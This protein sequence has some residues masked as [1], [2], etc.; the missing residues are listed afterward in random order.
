MFGSFPPVRMMTALVGWLICC[1][2]GVALPTDRAVADEPYGRFQFSDSDREHWSFVPPRRGALPAVKNT[3]WVKNPIDAFV[4]ARLEAEGLAPNPSADKLTLLRRVY[5]DL[6]GLAPTPA[7]QDAFL[8]DQ[9]PDA[10]ARVVDD[11]LARPAYGERWGRHWLDVVRYAESNGYERDGAK[12]SAWRYRDYVINAF[13]NDKPYDRFLTEQLAGDELADANAETCIATTFLR[14]GPWDDEPA[15]ALIDRYDQLDDVLGTASATFLAQTL[16]CARCHDHKF[17]SFTQRDYT[18]MLAV[19]EPLKRPQDGRTDLDRMVGTETELAAYQAANKTVDERVATLRADRERTEWE[20]C[21]RLAGAGLLRSPEVHAI[22]AT[23]REQPQTWR[24]CEEAPAGDWQLAEFDATSWKAGPGGFG[25]EG[26]PGTA[27]RTRW[28]S[29]ELWLR[30]DFELSAD[31]L[32]PEQLSRLQL[33]VHHDDACEI[34]L[35]GVLAA[36]LDGFTVEYKNVPIAVDAVTAL[37]PGRNVLAVHCSQTTGGQY[38]DVGLVAVEATPVAT[39]GGA[40]AEPAMLPPEAVEALLA[41]PE[42]RSSKQ[43]ELTKKLRP[44]L[45]KLL[46]SSGSDAERQ[47]SDELERQLEDADKARPAPLASAYV[48]F[49]ESPQATLSK[50]W[51]RGNPRESL[52]EVSAGFPAILVEQAPPPPAPTTKSTG[53]RLQLAQWLVAPGHPLTARVMANRIWQHHFGDGLVGTE[54][55]FGV[56]GEMPT[57]PELLDWLANEFVASGWHIKALHRLMVL[58][59][60]YQ[61]SSAPQPEAAAKDP[62]EDLLWRFPPRRLEAEAIR[63]CVLATSGQL[64]RERG[65]PS[66]YPTISADILA[67]QSRPGNGWGKSEPDQAARRSVY[68]FVKRTLLVPELE[69]LDFPDTNGT[70]EQRVVSTVAPQALT[71]LNGAFI[72]EQAQQFAVRLAREAGDNTQARVEL[73]YRLSLARPATTGERETVL[74]F[75]ARHEKQIAADAAAASQNIDPRQQALEAFCLVL[76]NSNE[77]VYVR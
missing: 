49:E 71:W 72:R 7:E 47:T 15:D 50:I 77:F 2:L 20:L 40:D 42:S 24:Y 57:H 32:P 16:R 10:L 14:L 18:R 17:E 70:C 12:P 26:T 27:V 3:D 69:V 66:V 9:A 51:K 13:N 29:A 39:G 8:A 53:R 25:T 41:P 45:K 58:S 38:I 46:A 6:I 76:L 33:A 19:F 36:K 30:R 67:S 5:L 64:N 48:W 4:L 28:A 65:G 59:N 31:A 1:A 21:K 11:L 54:N 75:L 73:A 23:S 68:V 56:M 55:D 61:M 52:G 62:A 22:V 60:T 43:R 44:K 63:D 37:R 35:N 34:Y 74:E